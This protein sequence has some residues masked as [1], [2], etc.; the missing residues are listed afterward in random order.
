[1]KNRQTQAGKGLMAGLLIGL[2]VGVVAIGGVMYYLN[3]HKPSYDNLNKNQEAS[4]ASESVPEDLLPMGASDNVPEF[5]P[6]ERPPVSASSE[7]LTGTPESQDPQSILDGGN[8]PSPTPPVKIASAENASVS[9]KIEKEAAAKPKV[10]PIAKRSFLQAGAYKELSQAESQK[11]KLALLGVEAKIYE[12]DL[13][14]TKGVVH[15]VRVGPF[16]NDEKLS[17]TRKE[18]GDNGVETTVVN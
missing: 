18:L 8:A 4:S 11:A 7:H 9:P 2:A 16:T 14:G 5:K 13:G 17:Q 6:G 3:N 12:V 10:E 15:R 1:M